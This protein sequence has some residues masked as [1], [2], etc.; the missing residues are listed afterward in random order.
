M[1]ALWPRNRS[2]DTA[3]EQTTLQEERALTYR[4]FRTTLTQQV[5]TAFC[6]PD[7]KF[8]RWPRIESRGTAQKP[9]TLQERRALTYRPIGTSLTQQVTTAI[10]AP[11]VKFAL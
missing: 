5:T 10:C 9:T 2:R 11:D 6:V 4:P 1:F 8:A 3:E 7:V